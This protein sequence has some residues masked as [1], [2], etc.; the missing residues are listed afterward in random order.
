MAPVH[1]GTLTRSG[2]V[3]SRR[4]V[5]HAGLPKTGTTTIQ[6]VCYQHRSMLIEEGVLYPRLMPNLTTPLCT[7][8]LQDPSVHISNRIE[9][10]S[11]DVLR[12]RAEG[13]REALEQEIHSAPWH[14]LVLSAEGVS[15]LHRESLQGLH[16][17][18][19][20]F[21]D[22]WTVLFCVRDPLSYTRSVIQQL[23]KGGD[24]LEDLYRN[25]PLPNMRGK[26]GNAIAVFGRDRVKVFGMRE[27]TSGPGGLVGHFADLIGLGEASRRRLVTESRVANESMSFEAVLVLDSLNRKFPMFPA[28]GSPR[29]RSGREL[30]SVLRIRGSRYELPEDVRR[31]VADGTADD[32]AWV[33][34][35][36]G[37]DLAGD[38]D[39]VPGR[40]GDPS[41]QPAT[42]DSLAELISSLTLAQTNQK[43]TL[44]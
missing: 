17:W 30:A 33:A 43:G 27:A 9:G 1:G 25:L 4:V 11:A 23:M 40:R 31:R 29:K 3:K 14:T 21:A 15:N 18:M 16:T 10:N 44:V 34:S 35:E 39:A 37:V 19:G 41:L 22:D 6:N 42:A 8:F 7:M 20:Q 13:F 28:D 24:R 36:F 26:I 38:C 5:L 12:S 2:A 32:V